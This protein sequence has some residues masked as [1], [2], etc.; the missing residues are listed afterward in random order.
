MIRQRQEGL[1]RAARLIVCMTC[2][3]G[4]PVVVGC[5]GYE[6]NT[7]AWE[8]FRDEA[9]RQRS[10]GSE[11]YRVELDIGFET[12][13]QLRRYFESHARPWATSKSEPPR[14]ATTR[15][16]LILNQNGGV[17]DAWSFIDQ[18]DL[19]YCVSTSFGTDYQ[20][21]VTGMQKAASAWMSVANVR[22]IYLPDEDS[23]CTTSNTAIDFPVRPWSAGGACAFFPSGG[24][25][26][27]GTL[28]MDFDDFD[29]N[30]FWP[31]N[32]PNLTD[33]GVF[34]HE[35]GHILGF[36]HEH[37]RPESGRC[38]EDDSWRELTDYDSDSIMHYPWCNGTNSRLEVTPL[39]AIGA[40]RQ[41]GLSLA[42]LVSTGI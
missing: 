34:A 40:A 10:D 3:V 26:V 24:G 25:C 27:P 7:D 1:H 41:Y 12:E 20:R 2:T 17:D 32:V 31:A 28:V 9:L 37:T 33:E 18:V 6:S 5:E 13:L 14:T 21:A 23:N 30:P 36:R 22:F 15:F 39:D 4:L 29:T 19:R 8:T 16:P 38:F 11:Y 42:V 35:L